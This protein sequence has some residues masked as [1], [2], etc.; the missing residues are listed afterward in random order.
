MALGLNIFVHPLFSY[1]STPLFIY[2][3]PLP[4][5][6]P[7]VFPAPPI[8]CIHASSHL[9]GLHSNSLF[10]FP[11][12]S[13][14]NNYSNIIEAPDLETFHSLKEAER[15]IYDFAFDHG[16]A[17]TR[18]DIKKDKKNT[19]R[20]WDFRCDKGG[21]QRTVGAIRNTSIR[22]AEC[23]F[24]LRLYQVLGSDGDI[25]LEVYRPHYNYPP[26]KDRRQHA[27]YR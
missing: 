11:F 2:F 21:Q 18:S 6:A 9:S 5:A 20:R 15:E 24:E 19:P 4:G 3:P 13:I 12:P 26:S 16:F 1:I 25:R 17:L 8:G 7:R 14:N 23:P 22:M 10:S 27:Q